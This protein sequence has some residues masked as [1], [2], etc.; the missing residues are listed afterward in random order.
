M[1]FS[2]AVPSKFLKAT[3]IGQRQVKLTILRISMEEVEVGKTKPILYFTKSKRGLVLNKTNG[4]L[5]AAAY[6]DEMDRW[7]GKELI[8]YSMKVPMQGKIVDA[9]RVEI[10]IPVRRAVPA[11][12]V[13]DEDEMPDDTL[14]GAVD[15]L[16][17]EPDDDIPY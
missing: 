17:G 10:P 16:P 8:L 3:D 11:P 4:L 1:K 2:E 9:L 14:D 5:L 6:G 15:D 13:V 12:V 7:A